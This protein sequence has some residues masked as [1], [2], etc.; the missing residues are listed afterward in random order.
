MEELERDDGCFGCWCRKSERIFRKIVLDRED[1]LIRVLRDWKWSDKIH[2]DLLEG[3]GGCIG[4]GKW[5]F[6]RL[7]VCFRHL[8]FMTGADDVGDV[9][10]HSGPLN[11][12]R[13]ELSVHAI[14]SRMYR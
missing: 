4:D 13:S 3:L 5:K 1:V 6:V 8:A 12:I 14:Y 11:L 10:F 7:A 9:L 2:R